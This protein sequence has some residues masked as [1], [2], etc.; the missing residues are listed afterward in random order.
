MC[1]PLGMSPGCP[2]PLGPSLALPLDPNAP[3]GADGLPAVTTSGYSVN[4]SVFSRHSKGMSL[5][6]VRLKAVGRVLLLLKVG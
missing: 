4:F 5:V 1:V 6:L 3:K 2:E